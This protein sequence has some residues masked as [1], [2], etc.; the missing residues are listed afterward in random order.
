[1]VKPSAVSV[2]VKWMT[3][4]QPLTIF[5]RRA[6]SLLRVRHSAYA[7]RSS[8]AVANGTSL[9]RGDHLVGGPLAGGE[10]AIEVAAPRSGGLGPCPVQ[11]TDGLPQRWPERRQ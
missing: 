10:R 3:R 8:S 5:V 9:Q 6:F 11:R 4:S 2:V 1:M 7:S